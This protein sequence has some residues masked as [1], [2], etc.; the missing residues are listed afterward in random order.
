MGSAGLRPLG[1]LTPLG[2]ALAGNDLF[3]AAKGSN[4]FGETPA[5]GYGGYSSPAAV[6][7]KSALAS[8]HIPAIIQL[9]V[10]I[11]FL[12]LYLLYFGGCLVYGGF[13]AV[14]MAF[15]DPQVKA[16]ASSTFYSC[17]LNGSFTFLLMLMQCFVAYGSVRQMQE[18]NLLVV[19]ISNFLALIPCVSPM[20][21]PSAV[22]SLAGLYRD[23][24]KRS[25][26]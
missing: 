20:G 18:R 7:G 23:E 15:N 13:A 14:G 6:P 26:R 1:G 9:V 25:F 5:S 17:L 11:P 22:W 24:V 2:P 19:Q 21:F 4:P 3:G 12:L 10:V 16:M 8:I